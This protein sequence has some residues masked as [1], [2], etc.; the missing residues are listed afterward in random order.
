MNE[1]ARRQDILDA[2]TAEL[3]GRQPLSIEPAGEPVCVVRVGREVCAVPIDRIRA[4]IDAVPVVPLPGRHPDV[5][6]LCHAQGRFHAVVDLARLA[7]RS[8]DGAGAPVHFLL[9]RSTPRVALATERVIGTGQAI[10]AGADEP[11][12]VRIPG[13][14][15]VAVRLDLDA[16]LAPLFPKFAFGA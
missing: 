14:A 7:G 12:S 3:A 8:A 16:L 2:R 1:R 11:G 4:V 13:L 10:D 9:L 15:D 6:G 5:R